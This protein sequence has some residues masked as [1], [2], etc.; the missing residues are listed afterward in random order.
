MVTWLPPAVT[1]K[2]YSSAHAV[3]LN[4]LYGS[5]NKRLFVFPVQNQVFGFCNL[6]GVCLLRGMK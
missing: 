4:V 3:N 6:D 5:E 1:L 2:N